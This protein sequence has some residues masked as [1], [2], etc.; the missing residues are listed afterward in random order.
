MTDPAKG[1]DER[2]FKIAVKAAREAYGRGWD[3][4]GQPAQEN[5]IAREILHIVHVQDEAVP[6]E[7]IGR[8]ATRMAALLV[9][10]FND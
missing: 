9:D 5:A 1:E 4:I 7:N 6:A 2:L 8:M 3:L 10:M